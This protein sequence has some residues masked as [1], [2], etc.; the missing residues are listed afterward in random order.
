[1]MMRRHGIAVLT[2]IAALIL[3]TFVSATSA[4]AP[5]CGARDDML[6]KLASDYREEPA[7]VALTSDGQLLE[8][9]KSDS[10]M[11]WSIL[12]TNPNGVTCLVA[13]GEGWQ[14]KFN[15]ALE[16]ET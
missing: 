13:T 1:M 10:L 9:L 8:V 11:T 6:T 7:S 16:P 12:I 2:A 4:A 5:I 15:A 14:D 3:P